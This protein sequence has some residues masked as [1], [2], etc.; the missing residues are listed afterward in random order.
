M[1]VEPEWLVE[2]LG[3]PTFRPDEEHQGPIPVGAGRLEIRSRRHTAMGAMTKITI[4]EAERALVLG[5]QLYDA[6]G[7]LIAMATTT[8][9]IRDGL[10]GVNM[11]RHI[12]L[13]LPTTQ[14][15]L[16][17]DVVNWQMNSLGPQHAGIWMLP[18]KTGAGFQNV[19]LADPNLQFAL[20][21]QP[22]SAAALDPRA[23]GGLRAANPG[24]TAAGPATQAA[25][26]PGFDPPGFDP[27]ILAMRQRQARLG[28]RRV[29]AL[30]LVASPP[31][32]TTEA[33]PFQPVSPP[34]GPLPPPGGPIK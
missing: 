16:Q 2:A 29:P 5:Q 13:Q 22:L 26:P 23:N 20:P 21:A 1:P 7:Q 12:E 18:D 8:N 15:K 32:G 27:A 30:P 28:I 10:S 14:M 33:P 11:P 9:H 4:V 17:I 34:V 24:W 19:D 31:I 3:L 25:L 6:Q